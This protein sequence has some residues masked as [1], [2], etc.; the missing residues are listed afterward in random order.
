MC[1][2]MMILSRSKIINQDF[3]KYYCAGCHLDQCYTIKNWS[4]NEIV[5]N[6]IF[7]FHS[8]AKGVG[9]SELGVLS[10]MHVNTYWK[11]YWIYMNMSDTAKSKVLFIQRE[12]ILA[13]KNVLY[14]S[15]KCYNECVDMNFWTKTFWLF[16]TV[17][18]TV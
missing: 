16:G 17:C 18:T 2:Y 12:Q 7:R 14:K 11:S 9:M 8:L 5:S 3:F 1:R 15:V 6:F 10:E 4:G 13:L